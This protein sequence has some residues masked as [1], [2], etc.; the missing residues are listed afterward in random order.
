MP[1]P[2]PEELRSETDDPCEAPPG[3]D[4]PLRLCNLTHS[5]G[6]WTEFLVDSAAGGI[7]VPPNLGNG[8]PI[9]PG[10]TRAFRSATGGLVKH[11]GQRTLSLRTVGGT[12]FVSSFA[13]SNKPCCPGAGTISVG[14]L[15]DEGCRVTLEGDGGSIECLA[16]WTVQLQ[17]RDGV[18]VMRVQIQPP[19][20]LCA[21]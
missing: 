10:R 17:K 15:T 6:K 2:A 12:E 21:R 18:Y 3:L 13:V 11:T 7:I 8:Y 9:M 19:C 20:A 14:D 1:E 5:E 4:M 16:N